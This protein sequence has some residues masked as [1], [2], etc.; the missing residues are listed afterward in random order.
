VPRKL[1]HA[2]SRTF[3][4]GRCITESAKWVSNAFVGF[5]PTHADDSTDQASGITSEL[6][7]IQALRSSESFFIQR[8]VIFS[9]SSGYRAPSTLIFE[10]A[11]WMSRR[12][13]GHSSTAA[14]P[15]FSSRRFS[16]VVPGIG[17]IHGF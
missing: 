2:R 5:A 3:G 8:P 1:N 9:K 10:A 17:T 13:S 11:L 14:A 16:F 15:M 7:A 12:S 6:H 4:K